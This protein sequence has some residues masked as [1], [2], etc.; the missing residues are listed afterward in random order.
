MFPLGNVG[1]NQCV[2][3]FLA[4][5]QVDQDRENCTLGDLYSCTCLKGPLL[6]IN[7]F[8]LILR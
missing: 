2:K 5:G 8:S 3:L 6:I 7:T 1:I 4:C